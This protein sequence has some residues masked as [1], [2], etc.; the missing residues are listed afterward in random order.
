MDPLPSRFTQSAPQ[1]AAS[2]ASSPPVEEPKPRRSAPSP[3]PEPELPRP[4]MSAYPTP[5][6]ASASARLQPAAPPPPLASSTVA[7]PVGG[8]TSAV[9]PVAVVYTVAGT[10]T[11]AGHVSCVATRSR[12]D[13]G[14]QTAAGNT[15]AAID[16]DRHAGVA[17]VASC[18]RTA[19]CGTSADASADPADARASAD[20]AGSRAAADPARC[21][22][23]TTSACRSAERS[24][25]AP[26]R[27]AG[28][29]PQHRVHC[30]SRDQALALDC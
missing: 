25:G 20:P 7:C 18:C 12:A 23:A 9:G 24:Y 8:S 14:A 1:S 3:R 13:G 4:A 17:P 22:S 11:A 16:I 29:S 10:T 26:A 5:A 19:D 30:G 2:F 6:P 27:A 28:G 15:H 21:T